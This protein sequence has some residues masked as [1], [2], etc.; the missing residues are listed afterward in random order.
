LPSKHP[1]AGLAALARHAKEEAPKGECFRASIEVGA[2]PLLQGGVG[3]ASI[4]PTI[5][6]R[7]PEDG[8]GGDR[9]R[10]WLWGFDARPVR[11]QS[12]TI[13]AIVNALA[14]AG[15]DLGGMGV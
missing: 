2:H 15:V 9:R 6:E 11:G 5:C 8:S 10:L 3:C 14:R 7:V 13:T 1:F 4:K 12:G